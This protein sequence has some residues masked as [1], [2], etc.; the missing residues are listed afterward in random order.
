M[1]FR[2]VPQDFAA[3]GTRPETPLMTAT[4]NEYLKRSAQFAGTK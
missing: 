3:S 4:T 1:Q 2:F